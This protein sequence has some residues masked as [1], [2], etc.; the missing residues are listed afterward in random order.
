MIS[1]SHQVES[2]LAGLPV[3]IDSDMSAGMLLDTDSSFGSVTQNFI[4]SAKAFD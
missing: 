3:A 1:R 4:Q 2:N